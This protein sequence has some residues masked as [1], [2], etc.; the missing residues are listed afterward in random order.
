MICAG[1]TGKMIRRSVWPNYKPQY[2]QYLQQHHKKA[3]QS[4]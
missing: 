4:F 1:N 3:P 2:N